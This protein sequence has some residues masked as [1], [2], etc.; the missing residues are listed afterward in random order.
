MG[1]N[2]HATS[3]LDQLYLPWLSPKTERGARLPAP[4]T[5]LEQAQRLHQ[6]NQEHM[7]QYLVQGNK[8]PLL[9][10]N[11]L[12]YFLIQHLQQHRET[13]LQILQYRALTNNHDNYLTSNRLQATTPSQPTLAI[14]GGVTILGSSKTPWAYDNELTQHHVTLSP[15]KLAER[16]VS[17]SE[18]LGFMQAG[19]YQR[20]EYWSQT[21]WHWLQTQTLQAPLAWRQDA[22]GEWYHCDIEDNYALKPAAAVY[23]ISYYEAE[24][25]ANYAGCRLPTEAQWEHAM[26]TLPLLANSCGQ[27]WEWCANHFYPY[28]GFV[29]FPYEA[30]SQSWFDDK[31]YSLRGGSRFSAKLIKRLSFRNFYSADKRHVFAGLRLAQDINP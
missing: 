26:R 30:Y 24:A 23:G 19:G 31:H 8:H 27:A 22:Q 11:Y 2:T 7:H 13:L 10:D 21:G 6:E 14:A 17:N 5:L 25:Y 9:Q 1:Q 18:Y 4:A 20:A 16:P 15:Y 12:L 3:G 28:P 29:A